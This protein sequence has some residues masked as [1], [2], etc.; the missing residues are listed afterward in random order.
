[1]VDYYVSEIVIPVVNVEITV[2]SALF[3][4]NIIKVHSHLAKVNVNAK[5]ISLTDFS[6]YVIFMKI[7]FDI[8]FTFTYDLDNHRA[9]VHY[10]HIVRGVAEDN[11]FIMDN[12]EA[13]YLS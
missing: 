12:C 9:S 11:M 7:M 4:I 3:S 8:A 13:G 1:M 5:V 2:D 6:M 10:E